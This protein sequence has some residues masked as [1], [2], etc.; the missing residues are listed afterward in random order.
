MPAKPAKAAMPAKPEAP[1]D[2]EAPAKPAMP[3]K[4]AKAAMPAKP[5]APADP[6][7]P[8]APADPADPADCPPTCSDIV[9]DGDFCLIVGL[10]FTAS[11]EGEVDAIYPNA[12]AARP[13][14]SIVITVD[15]ETYSD[16]TVDKDL[17][18]T[19]FDA[20]A[21]IDL[22]LPASHELREVCI[23]V[24]SEGLSAGCCAW[25]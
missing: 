21:A 15:G 23:T 5:E 16:F 9:F 14:D 2:P 22:S 18:F 12:V 6:E 10:D 19:H 20:P 8:A 7:P 11:V 4:P 3:A 24:E 1:A 13:I 17:P 25:I